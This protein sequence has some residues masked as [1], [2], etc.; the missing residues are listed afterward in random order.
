M[1]LSLESVAYHRND[2]F[3]MVSQCGMTRMTE[4][5]H[6]HLTIGFLGCHKFSPVWKSQLGLKKTY[7]VP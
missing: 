7:L 3:Y 5:N 1:L 2:G 4:K 6:L